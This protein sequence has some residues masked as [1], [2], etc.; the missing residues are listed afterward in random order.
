MLGDPDGADPDEAICAIEY[1]EIL[2]IDADGRIVRAYPMPGAIPSWIY[3]DYDFVF[4]GRIGDGALPDS[5][6][7]RIDRTTMMATVV[8]IP[9]AVHP[10]HEWPSG[11]ITSA[12]DQAAAYEGLVGFEPDMTGTEVDSWI[13]RSALISTESTVS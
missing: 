5:T 6:L 3:V 12:S 4:A 10:S 8:L 7:V 9:A 11:W 2:L 13:G 1:G